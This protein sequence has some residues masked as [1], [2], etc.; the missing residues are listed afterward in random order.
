MVARETKERRKTTMT[1]SR[2]ILTVALTAVAL[3]ALSLA[4]TGNAL[5]GWKHHHHHGHHHH[6]HKHWYGWGGL[7]LSAA[8]A[9]GC[10][11]WVETRRGFAKIYVCD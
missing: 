5:A 9:S 1:T 4:G 7:Y 10:W 8:V 11:K 2:K 3:T 6:H